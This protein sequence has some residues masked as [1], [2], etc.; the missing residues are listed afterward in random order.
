MYCTLEIEQKAT[1]FSVS[2]LVSKAFLSKSSSKDF[3]ICFTDKYL[4]C[5]SYKEV[6]TLLT[7]K[8]ATCK[9]TTNGIPNFQERNGI[10]ITNKVSY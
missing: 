2:L 6:M 5:N 7:T 4:D 9:H 10:S 8:V 1:Y 3:I